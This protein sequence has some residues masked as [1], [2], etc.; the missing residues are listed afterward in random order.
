MEVPTEDE[1]RRSAFNK[2]HAQVAQAGADI[3]SLGQ[4]LF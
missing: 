2:E 3:D 4:A 1:W